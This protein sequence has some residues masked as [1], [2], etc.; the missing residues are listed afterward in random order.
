MLGVTGCRKTTEEEGAVSLLYLPGELESFHQ[1]SH[2]HPLTMSLA[3]L[4]QLW[5][6]Q[7]IFEKMTKSQK[8]RIPC[9]VT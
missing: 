3:S 9:N 6:S 1:Y 2:D 4:S 8:N 7:D 5:R